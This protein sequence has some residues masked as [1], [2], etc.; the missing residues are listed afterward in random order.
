MK[1]C[2]A[3][4]ISIDKLC[5]GW[6]FFDADRGFSLRGG[7]MLQ[8]LLI[9]N[10]VDHEGKPAG[11]LAQGVGI[12]IQWQDGPI[13]AQEVE[14]LGIRSQQ[15][16]LPECK[17]HN[18]AFVEGVLGAAVSRLEWYQAGPW[19]CAENAEAIECIAKAL[20]A[21]EK[22]TARR[23]KAGVE[24]THELG[25]GDGSRGAVRDAARPYAG[26]SVLTDEQLADLL[27]DR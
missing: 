14:G 12:N 1:Q 27:A 11:G 23:V 21:L 10:S 20:A 13:Q 6:Y 3:R 25:P 18:G 22:R 5:R 19:K 16:V 8:K 2:G 7:L 15:A 17:G 26:P 9:R 4:I 24:E